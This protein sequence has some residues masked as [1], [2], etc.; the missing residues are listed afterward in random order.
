MYN[1]IKLFVRVT[2]KSKTQRKV[3]SF[4]LQCSIERIQNAFM[5][6]ANDKLIPPYAYMTYQPA[7]GRYDD[8]RNAGV[9]FVEVAVYAGDRGIN[10][11]SG[12]RPFRPGFMTAPGEYDFQYADEDFRLA[13]CGAKPGEAYILPRL[14]LEMPTWWEEMYPEAQCRDQ[15]GTPTHCSYSSP[16]WLAACI[17]AMEHF[18]AWLEE[19]GWNEYIVGWHI[20]AGNTEEFVR[21]SLHHLQLQD[22]SECSVEAYRKW[23][24]AKYVDIAS[25]NAAWGSDYCCFAAVNPPP[26]C[27]RVYP[28]NG[29]LRDPKEEAHVIDYEHF[30]SDEQVIF[31]LK[32]AEAGKRIT[33]RTKLM[34]AF[35]GNVTICCSGEHNS[36]DMIMNSPDVDFFASPFSYVDN[37]G[38]TIDWPFQATLESANLHGKPWFVEADVRTLFSRPLSQCMKFANPYNNDIYDAPVW[39]GPDTVEKSLGDMLRAFAKILMHGGALWWFDMW[40]GWYDHEEFMKFHKWA[41]QF[42]LDRTQEGGTLS[43]SKIAFFVDEK[44]A[45]CIGDGRFCLCSVPNQLDLLGYLG[46]PYDSYLLSDFESVDPERYNVVMFPSPSTLTDGQR[47]HLQNWKKNNRGIIFTGY[48]SYYENQLGADSGV[49]ATVDN[50]TLVPLKAIWN[51]KSYPTS[52]CCMGPKV[53]MKPGKKDVVVARNEEGEPMAV[54]HRAKDH[55]ILWSVVP[56]LPYNMVRDFMLLCGVHIY[57]HSDDNVYAGGDYLTVHACSDGVKRVWLPSVGK[58]YDVFTGER[59][60]GTELFVE[61]RMK[62]GESRMLRLECQK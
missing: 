6:R 4:M 40:G 25:L 41:Y 10:A 14:M 20:A 38:S 47:K 46:A 23:L 59:V 31:L 28:S 1:R 2:N 34:G 45:D 54:L 55:Q 9:K 37:R 3:N 44:V 48:P 50:D 19:S 12:T 22:Y 11:Y 16:V 62:L 5:I 60:M 18:H 36:M 39:F 13:T 57:M 49:E 53:T 30:F 8:F 32:L 7:K 15:A 26:P 27:D 33:N 24:E 35:Y 56:E 21:M 43:K 61:M 17:E 51:G 42:Y 29:A 58:A 52:F